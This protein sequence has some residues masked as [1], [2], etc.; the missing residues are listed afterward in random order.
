MLIFFRFLLQ[1]R[2]SFWYNIDEL[3]QKNS[4][5]QLS[6]KKCWRVLFYCLKMVFRRRDEIYLVLFKKIS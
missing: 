5:F 3:K 6:M 1:K 4:I 2:D